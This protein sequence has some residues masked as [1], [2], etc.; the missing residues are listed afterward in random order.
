MLLGFV[1]STAC[2]CDKPVNLTF[3][4]GNMSSAEFIARTLKQYNIRATFFLANNPTRTGANA[5]TEKWRTFWKQRV[6]EGHQFGNHTWSHYFIRQD[7]SDNWVQGFTRNGG[8]I[9][10]DKTA[11][12]SE[13]QH[14]GSAFYALTGKKLLPVWRAP[15]G[16]TTQ[17]TLRWAKECGYP[18]HIGWS[19]AG[20]IHDDLSSDT[21]PNSML[22]EK[23]SRQIQAGDTVLMHLGVWNRKVPAATILPDLIASLK[24]RG[25]CFTPLHETHS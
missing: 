8:K 25:L 24:K 7:L 16:R 4:V 3:D 11:F 21:Y 13:L 23:A 10:L 18:K 5:L 9:R 14:V 6:A 15:A 19:K 1:C 20:Y 17:N 22:L 2:A 12:C